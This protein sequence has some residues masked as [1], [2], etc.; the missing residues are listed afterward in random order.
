MKID[1]GLKA[2]WLEYGLGQYKTYTL[3][4]PESEDNK[5]IAG[6]SEAVSIFRYKIDEPTFYPRNLDY[7][8]EVENDC[9]LLRYITLDDI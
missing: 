3:I 8:V 9:D 5:I 4:I 6:V 2:N 7:S 1:K